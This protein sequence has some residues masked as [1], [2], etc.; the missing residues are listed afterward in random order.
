MKTKYPAT[1]ILLG[2]VNNEGDITTPHFFKQGFRVKSDAYL[3]VLQNLV[4]P[5]MKQVANG[6]HF[7]F[8]PPEPHPHEFC[9]GCAMPQR[10]RS[11]ENLFK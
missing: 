8:Q 6:R 9:P 11:T 7:I 2:V 4:V 10:S 3:D 1:F 5:W